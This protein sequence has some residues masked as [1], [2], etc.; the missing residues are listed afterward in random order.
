[1]N[2]KF[3]K[4]HKD[5]KMPEKAH[6]RDFGHDVYAISEKEISPGV[7]Q[8]GLGFGL[9]VVRDEQIVDMTKSVLDTGTNSE[10]TCFQN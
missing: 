3:V 1:M 8:Y 2:V 10:D 9:Q 5:A 7:W 6:G 4:Y